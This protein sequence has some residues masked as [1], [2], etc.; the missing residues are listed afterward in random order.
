VRERTRDNQNLVKIYHQLLHQAENTYNLEIGGIEGII[1]TREYFGPRHI[2]ILE[3]PTTQQREDRN[4][5]VGDEAFVLEAEEEALKW[6]E[7]KWIKVKE[8]KGHANRNIEEDE[9]EIVHVKILKMTKTIHDESKYLCT[10]MGEIVYIKIF[11]IHEWEMIEL[12]KKN[13]SREQSVYK[14]RGPDITIENR[15]HPVLRPTDG[16]KLEEMWRRNGR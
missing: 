10:T 4:E 5:S 16:K 13:G 12:K 11:K 14:T 15:Q 8:H 7:G 9:D 3:K 6:A 1:P 2:D